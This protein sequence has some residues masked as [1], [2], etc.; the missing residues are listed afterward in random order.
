MAPTKGDVV[1]IEVVRAWRWVVECPSGFVK[2]CNSMYGFVRLVY[3]ALE[4]S[5]G[6]SINVGGL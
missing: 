6:G 2:A 1:G 3:E 4:T 5:G